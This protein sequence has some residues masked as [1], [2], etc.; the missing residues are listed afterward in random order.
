[1]RSI[2][3]NNSKHFALCIVFGYSHDVYS[4]DVYL[5]EELPE[6][7]ERRYPAHNGRE[8]MSDFIQAVEYFE[9]AVKYDDRFADAQIT[10]TFWNGNTRLAT[11]IIRG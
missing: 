3:F 5:T 6:D 7:I 9:R 10:I 8:A 1:M 2:T 11:E 4:H